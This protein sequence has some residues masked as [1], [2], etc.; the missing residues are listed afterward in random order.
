MKVMKLKQYCIYKNHQNHFKIFYL[1]KS[2]M[3][4]VFKNSKFGIVL[5]LKFKR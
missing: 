3:Y 5:L 1:H 4:S 2:K